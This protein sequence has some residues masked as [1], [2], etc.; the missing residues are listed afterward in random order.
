MRNVELE[1]EMRLELVLQYQDSLQKN[2][3]VSVFSSHNLK[4]NKN[5]KKNCKVI[6]S[7]KR[8]KKPLDIN[9]HIY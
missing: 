6:L 7:K 5:F 3:C 1:K 9:I 2:I 8:R 4:Y